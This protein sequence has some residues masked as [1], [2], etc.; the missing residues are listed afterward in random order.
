M[1]QL[2]KAEAHNKTTQAFYQATRRV[3]IGKTN[4]EG[5]CYNSIK[6]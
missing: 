5:C 6:V 1:P 3:A 2:G 4:R